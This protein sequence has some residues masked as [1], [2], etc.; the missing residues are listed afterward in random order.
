MQISD[1][2]CSICSRSF[3]CHNELNDHLPIHEMKV[4]TSTA[5]TFEYAA[6]KFKCSLCPNTYAHSSSFKAHMRF[7]RGEKPYR[8]TECGVDFAQSGHL[9]IHKRIHTGEKPYTCDICFAQFKQISHLKTHVRTHTHDK[10]YKCNLCTAAF[11]QNSSLKRHKRSHT[12]EKPY[13]CNTCG[14]EF[15]VKSNLV[16]HSYTHS[17]KKPY[18]CNLCSA[19]FGQVIDLRRHKISHTGLKPFK[20]D[21]CEAT[22][23][24]KNNL[25][26]HKLTHAEGASYQCDV[27]NVMFSSPGDLRFHKRS[28]EPPKPYPC[29]L[30]PAAF[31]QPCSLKNHELIHTSNFPSLKKSKNKPKD[32]SNNSPAKP[33]ACDYCNASFSEKRNWKRHMISMH[34]NVDVSDK[35]PSLLKN[36]VKYES[37]DFQSSLA[38]KLKEEKPS[39]A[40]SP[41]QMDSYTLAYENSQPI[42]VQ[43]S[44]LGEV[45]APEG[46]S[47]EQNI[48]MISGVVTMPQN[49]Q[50]NYQQLV[51]QSLPNNTNNNCTVVNLIN[52]AQMGAVLV[53]NS[54]VLGINDQQLSACANINS[55][56]ASPLIISTN[57]DEPA[58]QA[59]PAGDCPNHSAHILTVV[60][61]ATNQFQAWCICNNSH[62]SAIPSCDAQTNGPA[63][64]SVLPPAPVVASDQP[65]N[66][67]VSPSGV[68]SNGSGLPGPTLM[69][70]HPN[71]SRN[72]IISPAVVQHTVSPSTS[73]W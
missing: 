50:Q 43:Q 17:G 61:A 71:S 20:C 68:L 1:L 46:L 3:S 53:N 21:L 59:K 11:A 72:A 29:K 36:S 56:V 24:R 35:K 51:L 70:V 19:S 7:H 66:G 63:V 22:F 15:V 30:C 65:L 18:S 12:G 45:M 32:E 67:L 44:V 64:V 52:A 34:S 28:H 62:V 27:C 37:S 14:M 9:M 41:K 55:N 10:P 23:S 42:E 39:E 25:K 73:A 6:E 58:K 38:T 31:Q 16:R 4:N 8:C 48:Q 57:P 5:D 49:N 47:G 54:S 2:E 13:K 69:L 40:A 26:W 60:D 33:F